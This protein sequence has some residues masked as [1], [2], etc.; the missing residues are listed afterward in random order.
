M[1]NDADNEYGPT[2]PGAGY[3]H[4][5]IDPS[6]GYRFGLWLGVAMVLSA[7]LVYGIFTLIGR[8]RQAH[9]AAVQQFPL[10]RRRIAGPAVTAPADP[11]V[12][13]RV[14]AQERPAPLADQLR[15][16]G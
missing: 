1:S 6:V 13:G 15:L 5:D 2:P 4:T 8:Q 12:Q 16:A 3:E 11:A 10:A 9:D 14:A 7:A